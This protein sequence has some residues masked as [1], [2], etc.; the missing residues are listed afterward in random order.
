MKRTLFVTA[1]SLSL[2]IPLPAT[3]E[4]FS[5]GICFTYDGDIGALNHLNRFKVEVDANHP[6]PI[7][8][9]ALKPITKEINTVLDYDPEKI[10]LLDQQMHQATARTMR[11]VFLTIKQ[12]LESIPLEGE[13]N[14]DL[15]AIKDMM[16]QIQ[17][18]NGY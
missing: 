12:Q 18:K 3:Q 15:T 4:G 13:D 7:V 17:E 2:A 1:L 6:N 10:R 9:A 14:P 8:N 11:I 16:K 5:F